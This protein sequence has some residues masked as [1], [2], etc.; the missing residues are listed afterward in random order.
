MLSSLHLLAW[1]AAVLAGSSWLTLEP[2][3]LHLPEPP[4]HFVEI[5]AIAT[6]LFIAAW[7]RV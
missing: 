3:V 7:R 6:I 1:S 2:G 4:K 5:A